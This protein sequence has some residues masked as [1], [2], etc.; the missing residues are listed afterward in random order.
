MEELSYVLT[1]DF[2]YRVLVRFYFFTAAHFYLAG[3]RIS[4][5]LTASPLW[6]VHVFRYNDLFII[7]RIIISYGVI[8]SSLSDD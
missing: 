4:H 2:V 3:A 5:F 1:K 7:I 6:N 8:F